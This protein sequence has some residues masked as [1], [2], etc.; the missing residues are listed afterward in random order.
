MRAQA[1]KRYI[2]LSFLCLAWCSALAG[3]PVYERDWTVKTQWGPV[4]VRKL[5]YSVP[6]DALSDARVGYVQFCFGPLGK[7][8]ARTDSARDIAQWRRCV[9]ALL[10]MGVIVYVA[11]TYRHRGT[12]ESAG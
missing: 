9:P 1:I 2:T 7:A 12:Y 10:A 4:G 6:N 5:S 11:W 3:S 8:T